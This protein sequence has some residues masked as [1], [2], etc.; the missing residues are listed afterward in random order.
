MADLKAIIRSP[1]LEAMGRFA[2]K[3]RRDENGCLVWTGATTSNGYG[4]IWIAGKW[5]RAHRF[6]YQAFIGEVPEGLELDHLCRNRRCC[7][8]LH[9][10]PVTHQENL[11][12]GA[13]PGR[14]LGK[15][16]SPTSSCA[17]GHARIDENMYV[18]KNGKR[19][20]WICKRQAAREWK[21]QRAHARKN[22]VDTQAVA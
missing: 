22:S 15:R 3:T 16:L 11:R 17:Q 12:R 21:A 5:M 18:S 14:K 2:A 6:S 19:R 20:C 10:E 8:P 13:R 7:D 9:V 1:L 4:K